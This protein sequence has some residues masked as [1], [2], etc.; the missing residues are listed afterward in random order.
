MIISTV[1]A[2]VGVLLAWVSMLQAP[3]LTV[4]LIASWGMLLSM[5]VFAWSFLSLGRKSRH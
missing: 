3:E 5:V 2:V 4:R 1:S